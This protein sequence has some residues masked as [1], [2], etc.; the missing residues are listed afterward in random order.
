MCIFFGFCMCTERDVCV[1]KK[2]QIFDVEH[3][4]ERTV[5]QPKPQP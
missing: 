1:N 3:A 4:H 2:I 5:M